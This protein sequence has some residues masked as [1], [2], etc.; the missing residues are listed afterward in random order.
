MRS[1]FIIVAGLFVAWVPF[2]ALDNVLPETVIPHN[3]DVLRSAIAD[4]MSRAGAVVRVESTTLKEQ[5]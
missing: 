2:T 5:R 1:V 3:G 4:G